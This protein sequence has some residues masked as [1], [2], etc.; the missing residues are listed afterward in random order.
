MAQLIQDFT[1]LEHA[2]LPGNP[3][4]RKKRAAGE[5]FAA[6]RGVAQRD[7]VRRRIETD[8]VRAGVPARAIGAEGK[9]SGES[10]GSHLFGKFLQRAGGR[11]LFGGMMNLPTPGFVFGM[12]REKSGGARNG[13]DK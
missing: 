9:R 2:L 1:K 4:R 13:F 5:S 7:G 10:R 6:A 3:A 8:F 12:L 11:I